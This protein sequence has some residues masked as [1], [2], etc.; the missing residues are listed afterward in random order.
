[1]LTRLLVALSNLLILS[2]DGLVSFLGEFF[3]AFCRFLFT[4]SPLFL[5][6][7]LTYYVAGGS[8]ATVASTITVILLAS[9]LLWARRQRQT[10]TPR[11]SWPVIASVI[12]LDILVVGGSFIASK[13]NEERSRKQR[14]ALQSVPGGMAP[15]TAVMEEKPSQKAKVFAQAASA[16]LGFV[17]NAVPGYPKFNIPLF[18]RSVAELRAMRELRALDADHLV[19]RL[20]Y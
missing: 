11:L 20:G 6:V 3:P 16:A 2:F 1:M 4:S 8:A 9:G 7:F 19:D 15:A 13:V 5:S 18:N 14:D 17:D 12:V 10:S